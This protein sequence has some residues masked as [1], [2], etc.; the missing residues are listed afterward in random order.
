M[1]SP[2]PDCG[3][4]MQDVP[5]MEGMEI[6]P[7]FKTPINSKPPFKFKCTGMVI[8]DKFVEDFDRLLWK[9]IQQSN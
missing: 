5:N 4:I 9:E 8:S 2:C 6:C 7:D 3:K 1:N